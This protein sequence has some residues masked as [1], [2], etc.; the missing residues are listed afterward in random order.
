MAV[1]SR[2][3]STVVRAP[4]RSRLKMSRPKWS[5]PSQNASLGPMSR[6]DGWKLSGS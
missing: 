4:Q 1:A 2:L 3:S 6:L 5:V